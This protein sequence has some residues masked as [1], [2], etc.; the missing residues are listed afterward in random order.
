LEPVKADPAVPD[1]LPLTEALGEEVPSIDV[2]AN[3]QSEPSEEPKEDGKE[4][5]NAEPLE[6][7]AEAAGEPGNST[8]EELSAGERMGVPDSM[9]APLDDGSGQ[10]LKGVVAAEPEAPAVPEQSAGSEEFEDPQNAP[11][12]TGQSI[13]GVKEMGLE[14]DSP[15]DKEQETQ[16]AVQATSILDK[17]YINLYF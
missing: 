12:F 15:K 2:D 9:G 3:P 16:E 7:L 6:G 11:E 4:A 13:G 5:L 1:G 14:L 17:V 10:E 8:Q